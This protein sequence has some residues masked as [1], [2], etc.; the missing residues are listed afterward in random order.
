MNYIKRIFKKYLVCILSIFFLIIFAAT[1]RVF[2]NGWPYAPGAT[3]NPGCGPTDEDCI[4][5]IPS[6]YWSK[7]GD[8]GTYVIPTAFGVA[9][10]V[11]TD[12]AGN[13][14]LSWAVGGSGNPG[15]LDTQ[16]QYND[17][18]VFGGD[19]N[20]TWNKTYKYLQAGNTSENVQLGFETGFSLTPVPADSG[21][22]NNL[23]GYQAGR[24]ITSGTGNNYFGYKTGILTTTGSHNNAFGTNALYN[25]LTGSF[26]VAIGEESLY[27]L[28]SGQNLVSIGY[29]TMVNLTTGEDSVAVG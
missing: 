24:A 10:S 9:G 15:G 6:N 18:G 28:T 25:N 29:G 13:G 8:T 12:A 27:T 19:A 14:A 26:I 3:L 5:E 17:N 22:Y 2:A 23:F 7:A 4:V 11:L 1:M 21:V 16:V 20:F